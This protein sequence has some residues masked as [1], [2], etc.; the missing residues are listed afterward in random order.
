MKLQ[1][2]TLEE[3]GLEEAAENEV[4]TSEQFVSIE[5]NVSR[6]G[7]PTREADKKTNFRGKLLASLAFVLI[8]VVSGSIALLKTR[9]S[10]NQQRSTQEESG[11]SRRFLWLSDFH[12][13]PFYGTELANVH[14]EGANC[15]R[16]DAPKFGAYGCGSPLALVESVVGEASRI[17]TVDFI[18]YSGDYQRHDVAAATDK[19]W[20]LLSEV[21][22][23]V[24]GVFE[25]H[26][27]NA[28]A[29]LV[30]S[31]V[32]GNN[33]FIPDYFVNV[34]T[35]NA[36]RGDDDSSYVPNEYL[37]HVAELWEAHL[38]EQ[39]AKSFSHGGYLCRRLAEGFYLLVLNTVVY[40]SKAWGPN[41]GSDPFGQLRWLRRLLLS[42]RDQ[43][44]VAYIHGHIPPILDSYAA[45]PMM[46][47]EFAEALN[48]L[49]AEFEDVIAAHLFGHLHSNEMRVLPG[50]SGSGAPLLVQG[51]T[52]PCYSSNPFFS[53]AEYDA[54][55][56][57]VLDF[58][59]YM[60]DLRG[61]TTEPAD[62]P[63]AARVFPSARRFFGLG[64]ITNAEVRALAARLGRNDSVWERYR[65][66][67][68]KGLPQPPCEGGCR[69][70]FACLVSDGY[71]QQALDSCLLAS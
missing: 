24:R 41:T 59:T 19:P 23:T 18:L 29:V 61:S 63:A 10:Q 39:E 15:R 26:F 40:S 64:E 54:R 70:R 43:G 47:P 6:E 51:S 38:S 9:T 52:A 14:L 37:A 69:G 1:Y 57:R 3:N 66:V 28:S 5:R 62:G 32:M 31:V 42:L 34:T 50:V 20:Q 68:Y 21:I 17:A 60:V 7:S 45:S 44:A 27:P 22:S 56:S 30:P 35:Q 71:S 11:N 33:D 55:T 67:W 16:K 46:K 65:D 2:S 8:V 4:V 49:F 25:R 53:V 48:Y 36:Y 12:L 13:D 58:S